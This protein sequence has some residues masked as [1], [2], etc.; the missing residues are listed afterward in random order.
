MKGKFTMEK[1][2]K[3]I[4]KFFVIAILFVAFALIGFFAGSFMAKHIFDVGSDAE[5]G[6]LLLRIVIAVIA[7]FPILLL[8]IVIH[9]A[10]HLV[11]GLL[12]GYGFSSFRIM[13][14]M[15]VK[16]DGKI[17]FRRLSITGTGG[18]CLMSPPEHVDGKMPVAMY[19]LGGSLFNLIFALAFFSIAVLTYEIELLS[20]LL[21]FSALIGVVLAL[22]NGIPMHMGAIDN[23]GRNALSLGKDKAALKAF[24]A[25]M[26]LN[27]QLTR[28]KRLKDMPSEWF[29]MPSDDA[30][31]N[32]MLASQ[33]VFYC[34]RLMDEERFDDAKAAIDHMLT[35]KSGMV[36]V[37]R[38]LLVCD[39][40]FLELIGSNDKQKIESLMSVEQKK[41]MRSMKSFPSIIRTEYVLCLLHDSNKEEA[42]KL[43][44]EFEKR[45]K[46]YP[47][48]SDIE[49]ERELMD[50]A[51]RIAIQRAI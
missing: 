14:Y 30:L 28:G 40:V 47:Y 17:R 36:G 9:V 24:W 12:S 10:G 43:R 13:S 50:V 38:N 1:N 2:K 32:S 45:A 41:F 15:W 11:F 42:E 22:M 5:S 46:S 51:D 21:I 8:N 27:E 35:V 37:H 7:Y 3:G 44:G 34:N 6:D 48:K 33:G 23:D 20:M 39:A 31:K 26:K 29:E 18:Q 16:E 25:Q 49:S 4:K 19:N